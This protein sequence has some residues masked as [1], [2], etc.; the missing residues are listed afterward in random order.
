M[1]EELSVST[2][3]H[4]KT[5]SRSR[6]KLGLRGVY[7]GAGC[8]CHCRVVKGVFGCRVIDDNHV[9]VNGKQITIVSNRDP[10][11]LPWGEMV[12]QPLHPTHL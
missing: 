9:S 5:F 1:L 11:K 10:T 3:L 4:T 8:A 7:S 12:S 2:E 6:C